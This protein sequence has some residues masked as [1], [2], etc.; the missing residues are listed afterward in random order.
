MPTYD[1]RCK[2]CGCTLEAFQKISDVPLRTCQMCGK[3]TL[4]RGP[5]G[6]VGLSFKGNGFYITDYQGSKPSE[7]VAAP[8]SKDTCCPC[9]KNNGSCGSK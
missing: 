3:E 7:P 2:A 5:G 9:G 4:V 8:A 6:G 1:Y